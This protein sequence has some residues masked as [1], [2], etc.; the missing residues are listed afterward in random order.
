MSKIVANGLLID[1]CAST[2]S[3]N[4][5]INVV[6]QL[7]SLLA[8]EYQQR[9][10]RRFEHDWPDEMMLLNAERF[11]FLQQSAYFLSL[12]RAGVD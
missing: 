5:P 12:F 3:P 2:S 10:F 11:L 8:C 9:L 1:C 7:L 4:V 6:F